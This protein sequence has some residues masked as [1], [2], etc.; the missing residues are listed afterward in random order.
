MNHAQQQQQRRCGHA[1]RHIAGQQADAERGAS[2]HEHGHGKRPLTTLLVAHVP[3]KDCADG[4][5]QKRQREHCER[6]DQRESRVVVREENLRDDDREIRV[7]CIVEPLDE[8]AEE[9]RRCDFADG[10]PLF[11]GS[12]LSAIC[13]G[14]HLGTTSDRTDTTL[15]QWQQKSP[16]L[17]LLYRDA[18]PMIRRFIGIPSGETLSLKLR[19]AS[20]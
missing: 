11:C 1:P 5:Q 18:P 12:C 7:S 14:N 15:G 9:R 10:A 19:S 16:L 13:H 2:H 4:S 6:L 3:P 8:V 17:A 20:D